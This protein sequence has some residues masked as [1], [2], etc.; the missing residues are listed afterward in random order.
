M[1]SGKHTTVI[2]RESAGKPAGD[3][4]SLS[5]ALKVFSSCFLFYPAHSRQA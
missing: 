5:A 2:K 3:A 1:S 4:A